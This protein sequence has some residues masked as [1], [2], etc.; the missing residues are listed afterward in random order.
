LPGTLVWSGASNSVWD[1]VTTNWL[2]SATP[3]AYSDGRPVKFDD[4][5]SSGAVS[6]AATRS[7]SDVRFNNNSLSYVLSGPG[8]LT[9]SA[10]MLKQGSNTVI[11]ANSGSNDFTGSI[12]VSAGTL[13]VGNG[14]SAGNLG[15]GRLT[16]NAALV[17]NRSDTLTVS[18]QISGI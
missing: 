18:N 14:G 3:A 6:L 12:T 13:Q 5:A 10:A 1:T 2:D 9:G 11:I 15:S 8:S 16:N 17:F 7:P 4:T